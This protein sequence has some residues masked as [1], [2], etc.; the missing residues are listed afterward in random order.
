MSIDEIACPVC[1]RR[2][3][4]RIAI[5]SEGG[6]L[7]MYQCTVCDRFFQGQLIPTEAPALEI[8]AALKELVGFVVEGSETWKERFQKWDIEIYKELG[9]GAYEEGDE[10]APFFSEAFLYNL[11][12]KEDARTV[13][14][15]L[16]NL[17]ERVM[18]TVTL[19]N[20]ERMVASEKEN[21][22]YGRGEA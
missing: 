13:R 17:I 15:L 8:V 11:L 20:I 7:P 2:G 6:R 22:G 1:Q 9:G 4:L 14:A 3:N 10:M 5:P 19:H 18:P 16:R 12:G 21:E